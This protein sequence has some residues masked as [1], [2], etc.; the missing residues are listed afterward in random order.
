MRSIWVKNIGNPKLYNKASLDSYR[1]CH[2]HFENKDH[3][4]SGRR[5]AGL[6]E[7]AVPSLFMSSVETGK[8]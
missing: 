2:V 5:G 6:A 1:V 4:S 7:K 8:Y 3:I